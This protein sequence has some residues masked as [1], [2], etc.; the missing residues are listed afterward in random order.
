MARC[1]TAPRECLDWHIREHLRDP[2]EASKP[3]SYRAL[4]PAHDDTTHSLSISALDHRV[5]WQCFTGCET[6][7]VRGE[8]IRAGVPPGCLPVPKRE[9]DELVDQIR[10]LYGKGLSHAELRWRVW[11]LVE[12]F[13]G[14]MPPPG[15]YP[16]GRRQF[17]RDAGVGRSGFYGDNR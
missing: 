7:A 2:R 17:T 6:L 8:L 1:D 12:G 9:A 11:S 14:E 4:C 10:S 13:S 15:R 5:T 3:G 16:G